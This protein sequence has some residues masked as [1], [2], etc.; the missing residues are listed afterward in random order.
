[1]RKYV[2][3]KEFF[4]RRQHQT[5]QRIETRWLTYHP[6]CKEANLIPDGDVP[7][8]KLNQ[9]VMKDIK[10]TSATLDKKAEKGGQAALPEAQIGLI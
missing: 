5:C 1:M 8:A 3:Q 6:K 7:L 9:L 10:A 4:Y 2:D